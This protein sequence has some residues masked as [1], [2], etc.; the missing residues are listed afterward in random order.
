MSNNIPAWVDGLTLRLAMKIDFAWIY[1]ESEDDFKKDVIT[2]ADSNPS[3]GDFK[4]GVLKL[5]QEN[6]APVDITARATITALDVAIDFASHVEG[7]PK[8]LEVLA[9]LFFRSYLISQ[10]GRIN[11]AGGA[12][13]GGNT[14]ARGGDDGDENDE[15]P[16]L[17]V[18][19]DDDDEG[20][21]DVPGT[22]DDGQGEEGD[23][24]NAG[25]EMGE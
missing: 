13:G 11:P 2:L 16:P 9:F 18:P 8:F 23:H 21:P 6:A 5:L 15:P 24:G 12:G 14:E 25:P 3:I 19:S 22:P 10:G 4:S 1:D 17:E 20:T 7:A